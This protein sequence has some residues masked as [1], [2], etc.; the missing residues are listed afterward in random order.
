MSFL[1]SLNISGSGISAQKMRMNIIAQNIAN[2]ETTN[3]GDGGP[4]LK[5]SVVFSEKETSFGTF[6]KRAEEQ[7]GGVYVS[8]IVENENAVKRVYDPEHPDADEFGYVAMP[9]I[10]TTEEMVDLISANR[11]YEANIT[12]F[13]AVKFMAAKALEIGK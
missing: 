12:A 8:Q 5:K 6:L 10:S 11:S 3:A 2:A 1:S 4:Y 13:N 9:E 7:P